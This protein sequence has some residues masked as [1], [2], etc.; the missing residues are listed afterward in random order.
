LTGESDKAIALLNSLDESQRK[1]AILS[2]RLADLVPGPGQDSKTIQS[3]GLKASAMNGDQ[4]A[5]L[6]D[7][8][9]EWTGIIHESASA[10]RMAEIRAGLEETWFAW[11][12]PTTVTPG[13]NITAY[14]GFRD[15]I[16]S[17]STR[18]SA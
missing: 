1:Q 8:I 10:A 2:Y 11:S 7:L 14:S 12:G 6:L 3:E 15:Q 5:I 18:L 9:S 17:L 4:R 13:R 16:S